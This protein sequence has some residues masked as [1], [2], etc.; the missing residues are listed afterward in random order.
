MCAHFRRLLPSEVF[1]AIFARIGGRDR[2]Q[3][4]EGNR[5]TFD[6][7]TRFEELPVVGTQ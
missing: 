5:L 1:V 4:L 7:F 3:V 2:V 6:T